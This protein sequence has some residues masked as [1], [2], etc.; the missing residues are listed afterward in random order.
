MYSM[1]DAELMEIKN[2]ESYVVSY[3]HNQCRW[4]NSQWKKER[5]LIRICDEEPVERPDPIEHHPDI[6]EL[7]RHGMTEQRVKQYKDVMKA[8]STLDIFERAIFEN[9]F[10]KNM[11]GPTIARMT[12][13]PRSQVYKLLNEVKRKIGAPVGK[14][15]KQLKDERK[16]DRH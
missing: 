12:G 10:I 1:T 4:Q 6:E 5:K 8:Y 9:Y 15:N 2:F 3:M 13:E 11:D 14:K 16:S 7:L